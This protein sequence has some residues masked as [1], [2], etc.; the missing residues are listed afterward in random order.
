MRPFEL[1]Y[2]SLT[3]KFAGVG[4]DGRAVLAV[5][6]RV[7]LQPRP[8]PLEQP[9]ELGLAILDREAAPGEADLSGEAIEGL[10]QVVRWPVGL[11]IMGASK[12]GLS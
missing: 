6:V 11:A 10:D 2:Y 3:L 7:E 8:C 5:N 9:D 4:K 1:R 12:D